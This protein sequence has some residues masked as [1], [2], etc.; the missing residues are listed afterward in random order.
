[1][2]WMMVFVREQ[3]LATHPHL[4]SPEQ[5]R[6]L[7][8]ASIRLMLS[9]QVYDVIDSTRSALET[10]KPVSAAAARVLPPLVSFGSEMRESAQILKTFLLRKLYRHPQVV[11]TMDQAKQVVRELFQVYHTAPQ[12][13]HGGF[14]ARTHAL[15]CHEGRDK[16]A[17][18]RVVADYIAGMTDRFAAREHERL[19]GVRLLT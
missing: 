13:M 15:L 9:A 14:A 3:A 12:E 8:Y 11:Q 2:M 6:R 5:S 10:A 4:N 18:M 17:A 16:N 7:L 19:T 1:M